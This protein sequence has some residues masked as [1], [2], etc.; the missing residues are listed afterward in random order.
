MDIMARLQRIPLGKFH[1]QLLVLVGLGWL[2]DAM[3]TGMVS[4]VL[5]TL[6]KE[7]AL[8]ANQVGWIVSVGFIGMALGAVLSGFAADR[9]GRKTVFVATMVVYSIATGLCA[10]AW[11]LDSLLFFR[12]WVGFGLGGQLPVAVSLVSEYA[13][14]KVRG[15][16]IVLLESFWG[17]G[18]LAAALA[19]YF[20]IP[21]YGWQSAFAIGAL[22]VF[23]AIVVWKFLPESV[24]YLLNKGRAEEAHALVSRLEREAGL[25]ELPL[26]LPPAAKKMPV[27]FGQL[28]QPPFAKRTLMLWLIWF[29][30]VF[31]YYGIFTWLPKLLVEQGHTVVKTFEYVLVMILAQLPGYFTAA[32]LV[33]KI[34]RKATLAGFLAACAVCAYCFGQSS[35]VAEIMLWG[36]LMSF[37]NLGAWGV[38]YTYT[39]EL[40]PVQFRAFGAGWAGA[41]GRIGGILAPLAVA[42]LMGGSNGFSHI[43]IM[44][45]GVLLAVVAVIVVLGEET[46]GRSLEDISH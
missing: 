44:F 45:A 43:F 21:H 17:L 10:L 30:I 1:Y 5:A 9:F 23:Y 18:W 40:Y 28:W 42:A 19:S 46:K 14:P 39:P 13:P 4:F 8:T 32:V 7:W 25:P 34:G 29:G 3:D 38:L 16:F 11:D 26:V 37:F 31:S 41:I 2:F 12:F 27:R 33:E 6:G 15:R 35:S 36:S 24:P 20:V 22:P